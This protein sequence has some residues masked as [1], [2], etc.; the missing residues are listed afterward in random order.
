M[1]VRE[2]M[3]H[4]RNADP[5]ATVLFLDEYADCDQADEVRQVTMPATNWTCERHADGDRAYDIHYPGPPERRDAPRQEEVTHSE[6]V[7][8]LSSG[9]TNLRFE[10]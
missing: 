8:V 9:P 1:K 5:E 6:R 2:L 4:L 7:V 10:A 3:E